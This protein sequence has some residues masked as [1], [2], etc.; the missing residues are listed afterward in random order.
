MPPGGRGARS[1]GCRWR[2]R[3]TGTER[4]GIARSAARIAF[5]PGRRPPRA[6]ARAGTRRATVLRCAEIVGAGKALLEL[7]VAYA[8]ERKQFGRPIGQFQAVQY[9]CTDIAIDTHLT[10]LLCHQ[11]AWRLDAG[12][13]ARREVSLAKAYA[14]RAVQ[15]IVHRAHEV[16]AG[17]AFM[18]EADVQLYTRRAKHWEFDLGEARYHD[19][20]S[21]PGSRCETQGRRPAGP[22]G[23]PPDR[24]RRQEGE[25]M[26][27]RK[28]ATTK[29]YDLD[30][31]V[32][33][34]D[35]VIEPG[36]VW[37]DRLPKNY[38]TSVLASSPRPTV[39]STGSTRT[40]SRSLGAWAP[41][42]GARPR[43]SRWRVIPT[44]RCARGATTPRP[45][46]P[47]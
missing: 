12:L 17:V 11:A 38:K 4:P 15:R 33:V 1:G 34:D 16:H 42:P 19:A 22:E 27:E 28:R 21:P 36:T 9:L 2:C 47:T 41:P 6:R 45:G 7:S 31:I 3:C 13:P 43:T 10:E 32:S 24:Q 30:W 29:G 37:T 26:A 46:W 20:W 44:A 14:S 8:Q 25:L 23:R 5:V 39:R 35:H 18:V 40:P